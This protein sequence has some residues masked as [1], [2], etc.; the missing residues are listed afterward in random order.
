MWKLSRAVE[1]EADVLIEQDVEIEAAVL[2]ENDVE[3]EQSCEIEIE[4]AV[5]KRYTPL[6]MNC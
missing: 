2:I 6:N 5:L 1:I 3:I 4:P